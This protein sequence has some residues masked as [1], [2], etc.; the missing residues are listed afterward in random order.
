MSTARHH[1]IA[2][3]WTALE[4]IFLVRDVASSVAFYRERLGFT[5]ESRWAAKAAS[6]EGT[7]GAIMSARDLWQLGGAGLRIRLQQLEEDQPLPA[8]GSIV[9]I[10]VADGIEALAADYRARGVRLVAEL[11]E[12]PDGTRTFSICDPNGHVLHFAE[13]R[14][15]S[16]R[17]GDRQGDSK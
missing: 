1:D 12:L 17:Q 2:G 11:T 14:P 9:L 8:P 3:R 15:S 5:V 7:P 6:G 13:E 16:A 4:P 10:A